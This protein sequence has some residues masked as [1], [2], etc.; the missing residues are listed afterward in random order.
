MAHKEQKMMN[1]LNYFTLRVYI[2]NFINMHKYA[3]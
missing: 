1:K 3:K 2:I